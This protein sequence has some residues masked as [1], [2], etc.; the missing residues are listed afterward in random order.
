M[1]GRGCPRTAPSPSPRPSPTRRRWPP[2]LLGVC[3]P[4]STSSDPPPA[5]RSSAGWRTYSRYCLK[6]FERNVKNILVLPQLESIE[7]NFKNILLQS[8][9][10]FQSDQLLSDPKKHFVWEVYFCQKKYIFDPERSTNCAKSLYS[11]KIIYELPHFWPI[12]FVKYFINFT[13]HV[14][15]YKVAGI[16]WH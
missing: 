15:D 2:S 6:I 11:V 14:Q 4:S 10:I 5:T 13:Y 16:I 3:P 7:W 9:K 12:I 1:T 8:R